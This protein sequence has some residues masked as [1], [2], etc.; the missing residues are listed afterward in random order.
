MRDV[1]AGEDAQRATNTSVGSGPGFLDVIDRNMSYM[2]SGTADIQ[3]INFNLTSRTE[4]SR[5]VLSGKNKHHVLVSGRRDVVTEQY[6]HAHLE[7]RI[8]KLN[9]VEYCGHRRS[10]LFGQY[11][12]GDTQR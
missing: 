11:V 8:S 10:Y 5:V 7:S 3:V 1:E 12:P 2:E 6:L 4:V 9:S